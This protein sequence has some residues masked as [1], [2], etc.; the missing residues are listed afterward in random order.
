MTGFDLQESC[1]RK[2][3]I[4]FFLYLFTKAKQHDSIISQ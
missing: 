4:G 2:K 1:E 3:K